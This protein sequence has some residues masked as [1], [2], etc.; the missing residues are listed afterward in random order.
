MKRKIIIAVIGIF[1]LIAGLG[2]IGAG[3]T[4]VGA[5]TLA[6][7]VALMVWAYIGL[8]K[9]RNAKPAKPA[10]TPKPAPAEHKDVAPIVPKPQKIDVHVPEM[11]G[12]LCLL[13]HYSGVPFTPTPEAE[14]EIEKMQAAKSW[15]LTASMVSDAPHAFHGDVDMGAINGREKMITDW[16]RKGD[17]L[18]VWLQSFGSGGNLVFLGFYRDEQKRLSYRESTV[19]KLTR[20]ANEDA[21]NAISGLQDG[22]KLD[23]DED[24]SYDFPEDTV[25]VTYGGCALGALPKATARKY[26]EES[27]AAVFLDHVDYDMEKDKEI[28]YVKI[29]W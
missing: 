8:Y 7:G 17:L 27:A 16:L 14:T 11:I 18:K 26:L 20:Y 3:D 2:G 22:L 21:Q 5:L 25:C 13:Y 24:Y 4:A 15:E 10:P 9:M 29:Y 23:F 6:I 1:F 28:P 12:D 19:V